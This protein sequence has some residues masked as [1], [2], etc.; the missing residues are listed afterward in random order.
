MKSRKRMD[1]YFLHI[2]FCAALPMEK[3]VCARENF[4]KKSD[5]WKLTAALK[6]NT[7]TFRDDWR[8]CRRE[9]RM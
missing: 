5:F 7:H 6:G 4:E 8:K 1:E 9:G 2:F 3:C